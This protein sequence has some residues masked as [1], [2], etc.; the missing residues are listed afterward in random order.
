MVA[1]RASAEQRMLWRKNWLSSI[2]EF[3]DLDMQ[4]ATWLNPKNINPH[5]SFVE[6]ICSYFDRVAEKGYDAPVA[7]G[8]LS[9]QE[10]AVVADLHALLDAYKPPNGDDYDHDAILQ[11]E[12]WHEVA[13]TAKVARGRLA[14]I[15]TQ[16]AELRALLE[17]S[18]HARQAAE[19]A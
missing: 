12:T 10:A 3:A 11:D 6:Y 2:A 5:Y 17:P 16:P 18:I 9:E 8:Y 13:A 19:K 4:R 7:A 1:D 15:I 14:A